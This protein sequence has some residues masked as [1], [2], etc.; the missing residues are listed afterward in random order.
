MCSFLVYTGNDISQSLFLKGLNKINYRGPD[1]Q[2][3][4]KEDG[5]WGFNRLA[6]MGL[7]DSGM[8]PFIDDKMKLVCNGE[9]YGFRKLKKELEEK[10]YKFKSASDC[11]I[12]IPLYKEYGLEMFKMLDA[13]YACVLFDGKDYIAARD[14]IG[15]RPMFYGYSKKSHK[16]MFASEAKALLQLCSEVYPFPIGSFY[17]QGKFVC[18]ND[19]TKVDIKNELPLEEIFKSLIIK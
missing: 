4:L 10:G 16:I 15:I 14:P 3:V 8:Q 19:L 2:R 7:E 1:N 9:I 6:I 12:L 11:E 18:Y 17:Y 13:E 5:L